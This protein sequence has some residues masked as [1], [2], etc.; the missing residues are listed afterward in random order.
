MYECSMSDEDFLI[1]LEQRSFGK[2]DIDHLWHL[3]VAWVY[4]NAHPWP[5]ALSK[6][7]ELLRTERNFGLGE[8]PY[9]HTLTVASLRIINVRIRKANYADFCD[10]IN[11]NG[12][13]VDDLK[14]VINRYYS[15]QTLNSAS[16]TTTY[17]PPDLRPIE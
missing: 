7:V 3:R 11:D 6:V 8:I 16:A 15:Q 17:V 14:G 9:H 1:Q 2:D 5:I 10:F 4:L 12:D 13:L